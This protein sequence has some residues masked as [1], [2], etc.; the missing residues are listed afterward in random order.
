MKIALYRDAVALLARFPVDF[1]DRL[2]RTQLVADLFRRPV[3]EVASDVAAYR[4][5]PT[6]EEIERR[7]SAR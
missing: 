2:S 6:R 7:G 1:P 4:R 3:H 5:R